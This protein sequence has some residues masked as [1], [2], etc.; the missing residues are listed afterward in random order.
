MS[1]ETVRAAINVATDALLAISVVFLGL[2][3]RN[4]LTVVHDIEQRRR[5]R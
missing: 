2:T 1:A 4:L 3:L 5:G